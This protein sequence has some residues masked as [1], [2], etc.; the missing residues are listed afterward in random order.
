MYFFLQFQ[1]QLM[2]PRIKEAV[3]LGLVDLGENKPQEIKL[4]V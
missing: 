1:K 3:N 2:F 4:E